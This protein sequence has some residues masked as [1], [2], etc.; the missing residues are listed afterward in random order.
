MRR[1]VTITALLVMAAYSAFL[2]TRP[3]RPSYKDRTAAQW[4]AEISQWSVGRIYR[5]S[6]WIKPEPPPP[7]WE[8][9]SHWWNTRSAPRHDLRK[10]GLV[11]HNQDKLPAGL[12]GDSAE[13]PLLLDLQD[14]RYPIVRRAALQTLARVGTKFDGTVATLTRAL[15]DLDKEVWQDAANALWE[16]DR[17]AAEKVGLWEDADGTIN[18]P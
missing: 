14:S 3:T 5:I 4:E 16:L 13:V 7:L 12:K 18:H 15:A 10:L 8:Q 2:L 17:E 1:K 11:L 9:L 6:I